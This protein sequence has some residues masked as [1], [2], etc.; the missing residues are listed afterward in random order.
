MYLMITNSSLNCVE[1]IKEERKK[2][3]R[4]GTHVQ[5]ILGDIITLFMYPA[6]QDILK[7]K[8]KKILKLS[9]TVFFI[10]FYS[11]IEQ[12]MGFRNNFNGTTFH[13]HFC[14]KIGV[15]RNDLSL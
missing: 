3:M 15:S 12:A 10:D 11:I 2:D 8:V 1:Y 6:K 5:S 14:V 4:F 9:A 7:N 13:H